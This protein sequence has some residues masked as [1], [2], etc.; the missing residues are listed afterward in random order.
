MKIISF[1][2]LIFLTT[3]IFADK[4]WIQIEPHDKTKIKTQK[5]KIKVKPI[6][7]QVLYGTKKKNGQI[8]NEKNWFVFKNTDDIK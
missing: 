1:T 5:E 3:N 4:N 7:K 6:I 2:L 8:S